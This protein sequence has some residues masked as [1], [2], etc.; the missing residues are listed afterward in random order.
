MRLT[1]LVASLATTIADPLEWNTVADSEPLLAEVLRQRLCVTGQAG[2][3]FIASSLT[4]MLRSSV[5]FYNDP[6]RFKY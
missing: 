3:T 4:Q 2:Y 1:L 6:G 5:E